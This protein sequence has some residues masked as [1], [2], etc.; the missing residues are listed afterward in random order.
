MLNVT[1]LSV[2]DAITDFLAAVP[3]PVQLLECHLPMI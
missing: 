2:F 1:T 3:T